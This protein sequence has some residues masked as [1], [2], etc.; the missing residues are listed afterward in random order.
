VLAVAGAAWA[1]RPW[2][3]PFAVTTV[4]AFR[5]DS[6]PLAWP[7]TGTAA[8]GAVGDG[9]L[10]VTGTD[11][12]APMAST[13]KLI[14][15]LTVLEVAPLALGQPGPTLTVTPADADLFGQYLLVNGSE[16]PLSPGE[17]MSEYQALQL[18]LIPSANDVADALATWFY[19]SMPRYLAATNLLVSQLGLT[20]TVVA[21][22]A[23]GFLPSTVSTP[24]DLV[25]LGEAALANPVIA[26]IADQKSVTLPSGGTVNNTDQL[27][28][29]DGIDG[30]KTG[31]TNQAGGVFIFAA[32]HPVGT[33]TVTVVGAVM[34]APTLSAAFAESRPLLDSAEANFATVTPVEA[35]EVLATYHVA[36]Q[37]AVQAVAEHDLS[38]VAWLG[39][40]IQPSLKL[41]SIHPPLVRNGQVGVVSIGAGPE[42]S[43][44][45]VELRS[46]IESPPRSLARLFA[47]R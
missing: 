13:A 29:V 22:D 18:M 41:Q 46:R 6:T 34:G 2:P 9:V 17:Q 5:Q 38:T 21:G 1:H 7:A 25:L 37:K 20:E 40:T 42:A 8:L 10:A 31:S 30:I 39:A 15:A 33:Q 4:P 44:S 36:W 47:R 19:G 32:H 23:S 43:S 11:S 26:S 3:T 12:P 35:G 24:D 14:T 16:V 28:G 45:P 27:L